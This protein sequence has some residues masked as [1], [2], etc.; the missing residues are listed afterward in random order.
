MTA[1]ASIGCWFVRF[2]NFLRALWSVCCKENGE[3]A[4]F[5]NFSLYL[6]RQTGREPGAAGVVKLFR[7]NSSIDVWKLQRCIQTYCLMMFFIREIY[8]NM[9]KDELPC[10]SIERLELLSSH[11]DAR[12]LWFLRFWDFCLSIF[13]C[14]LIVFLVIIILLQFEILISQ[15]KK[16]V[17]F[18]FQI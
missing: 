13:F 5:C 15:K 12:L 11:G 1:A 7:Q 18:F 14:L 10:V 6:S 4:F 3:L 9:F 16:I 17:N 2:N 8:D